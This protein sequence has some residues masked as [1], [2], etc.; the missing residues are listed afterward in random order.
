MSLNLSMLEDE[1]GYIYMDSNGIT[2][3]RLEI[4]VCWSNTPERRFIVTVDKE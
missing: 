2:K 3:R 1:E 4:N